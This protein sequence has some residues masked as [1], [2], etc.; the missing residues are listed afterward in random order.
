MRITLI[1]ARCSRC[2]TESATALLWSGLVWSAHT[3]CCCCCTSYDTIGDEWPK[4]DS[5][6]FSSASSGAG[7]AVKEKE[8]NGLRHWIE[9]LEYA[10]GKYAEGNMIGLGSQAIHRSNRNF[11]SGLL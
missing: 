3:D 5:P 8:V 6:R 10:P 11:L 4:V 1:R 7:A 2:G 9:G